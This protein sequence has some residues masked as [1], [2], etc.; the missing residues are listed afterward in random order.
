MTPAR[1][2]SVFDFD[3]TLVHGDSVT[4]FTVGYL[5]RR[6]GRLLFM[7]P[8][9]VVSAALVPFH[10]TRTPGVALFWWALTWGTHTRSLVTALKT[11]AETTLAEHVNEATFAELAERLGRDQ[12]VVVA[13]A[14]PPVLVHG[15]LRARQ[16]RGARVVG[17]P[18]V[19]RLGG[20]VPSPHCIGATKVT[21]LR[22]RFGLD[23]W[24]EVYT[25]SAF[26]L[27]IVLRSASVNLVEPSRRTLARVEGA[28]AKDVPLR[29]FRR[30]T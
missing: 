5:A 24:A 14:A 3:G 21:E 19:R 4:R 15:V 18:C 2:V 13:T 11:F 17:T 16:L 25:D 29:I 12:D 20:L 22:R 30:R 23:A 27:P 6:P 10:A 9:L 7:L 8:F 26:D 28:L 1:T